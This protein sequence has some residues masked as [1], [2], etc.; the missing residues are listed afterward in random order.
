LS[1]K[2]WK[3]DLEG[4]YTWNSNF[5]QKD[6]DRLIVDIYALLFAFKIDCRNA[7]DQKILR[8]V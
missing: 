8:T 7:L 1:P 2:I 3:F 6:S 4:K 5:P